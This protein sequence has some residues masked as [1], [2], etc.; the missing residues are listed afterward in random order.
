MMT[1]ITISYR[2]SSEH[3]F[4]LYANEGDYIG[5]I[6]ERSRSFYE[7]LLLERHLAMYGSPSQVV[8]IGTNIGNHTIFWTGV[9]GARVIAFEPHP[10]IFHVLKKN[11]ARNH[12]EHLAELCN[13]AC[14]ACEK[15]A[16]M[17]TPVASNCGT[18]RI[19]PE[20]PGVGN[21]AVRIK[22]ST[23]DQQLVSR[24]DLK[25]ID[26]IKIDTEGYEYEVLL[27]ATEILKHYQ[28]NIWIDVTDATKQPCSDL[29]RSLGYLH[30]SA[31]MGGSDNFFF[32][33][34]APNPM[35]PI[36]AKLYG[37]QDR[38]MLSKILRR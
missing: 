25:S 16:T 20:S 28:P 8:D 13:L 1:D 19:Q 3:R 14:G 24:E 21:D 5:G 31:P 37:S 6:L 4:S 15:S 18:S 22:Q 11:I 10:E 27:G 33:T 17:E 26:L 9:L 32:S 29:L 2:A 38:G 34:R 7:I 30:R 23:L 36:R 35:A 12:L